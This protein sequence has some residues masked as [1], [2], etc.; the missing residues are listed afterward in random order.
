M[1]FWRGMLPAMNRVLLIPSILLLFLTF[2]GYF[3]SA[4]ALRATGK[5]R[6]I[7]VCSVDEIKTLD[8]GQMSW[9]TEIR[10]AMALWEGLTSYDR[11]TLAAVPGVAQSWDISPDKKTYTFHLRPDAQWSNG[12]PVTAQD[13][14][15]AWKRV[16]LPST[17]ANYVSFFN[18][19]DGGEEYAQAVA[20]KKPADFS[21]VGIESPDPQTLIVHLKYP[22]S[23]FLDLCAFPT[24]FPLNE[25]SMAFDLEDPSHPSKGYKSA[26]TRSPQLVTNGPFFLK[27]WKFKQYMLLEPNPHYWD[28]QHVRCKQLVLKTITDPRAALLAYQSGTVDLLTATPPQFAQDLLKQIDAGR[29]DIH[30]LSVFGSY[31]YIFNCTREPLTD[32]RVR[33]ALCLAIDRAK[34]LTTWCGCASIPSA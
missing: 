29:K 32:K 1:I 14:I 28:R 11:D 34:S 24:F 4:G 31:Y 15:F 20:D 22:R 5:E 17:G 19:I 13:F 10:T 9:Q 3:A 30:Y 7:V 25:K 21:K 6:P 33:K 2:A 18:L 23:Y 27:E 26:W 8:V 16:F 12:E